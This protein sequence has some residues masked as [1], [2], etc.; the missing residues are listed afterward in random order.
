MLTASASIELLVLF[1]TVAAFMTRSIVVMFS[2]VQFS[3]PPIPSNRLLLA[4]VYKGI[5]YLVPCTCVVI[6]ECIC[7]EAGSTTLECGVDNTCLCKSNVE[8]ANCDR[9]KPGFVNLTQSNPDGC[10][11]MFILLVILQLC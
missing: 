10:V 9:C 1:V 6:D 3:Y 7:N 4:T 8:G 2:S 5:L 11:G